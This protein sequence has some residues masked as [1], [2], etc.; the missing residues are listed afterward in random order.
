M[1]SQRMLKMSMDRITRFASLVNRPMRENRVLSLPDRKLLVREILRLSRLK[2]RPDLLLPLVRVASM[3]C[4][5]DDE[6]A[7]VVSGLLSSDV[8]PMDMVYMKRYATPEVVPQQYAEQMK[9]LSQLHNQWVEVYY[10]LDQMV[11][12]RFEGGD[13]WTQG[14]KIKV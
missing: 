13:Q 14:E 12:Y 1:L 10:L 2:D 11:G 5:A 9:N 7:G 4:L 3:C 6:V 8:D